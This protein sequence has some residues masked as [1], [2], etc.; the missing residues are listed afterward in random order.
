LGRSWI[1]DLD[2]IISSRSNSCFFFKGRKIKL[3]GL[4]LIPSNN[5]KEKENVN[6]QGLNTMSSDEFENEVKE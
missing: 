4:P 1:Y 2:I 6:E 5:N 3:I